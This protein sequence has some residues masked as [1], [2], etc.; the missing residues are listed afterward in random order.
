MTTTIATT[1]PAYLTLHRDIILHAD[2]WG[3]DLQILAA[4]FGFEGITGIATLQTGNL[5]AAIDAGAGMSLNWADLDPAAPMR[6]VTSATSVIGVVGSGFGA[7]VVN[8][9]AMP[10]EFSFP[11]L[12]STLDPTD[13]A[14]T[15]NTGEVVTPDAAAINP[16]YDLNERSTVVV[17]GSF[18]NRLTPGTEG[19]IYPV[20]IEIVA[21]DTPLMALGPDGLVSAVGLT[22]DSTNPYV[23]DGGPQLV[24][25]KLTV[26]SP[27]G[28]FAPVGIGTASPNDGQALYGD[29]AEYRLRLFTSGGFSP[30]GVSGFLPDEFARFF[31]LEAIDADGRTVVIDQAGVDYDLGDGTLRVVGLAELGNTA[32][33]G[34]PAY[35]QE[36]HDNQ[37]D[38]VLAG[39]EAAMRRLTVVEIPTAAEEGYSD[40]YNPGGPGQTPT[41][42]VT[43]TQPA[44]AQRFDI[45]IALDDA[46]AVSYAAQSVADYDLADNLSVVF[47]L[48]DPDDG[49]HVYTASTNEASSFLADGWKELG[50]PFSSEQGGSGPLQI[51]RLYDADATDYVLTAD[52]DEI[53]ALT[54][55][56]YVDEG[57]VFYGL[58]DPA[59]GA[60]PIYRFYSRASSD[61]LYTADR[62]AG[63]EAGY[64]LE[65]VAWYAVD[66][67]GSE[68]PNLRTFAG[69]GNDQLLG[70][71]GD[72]WFNGGGG[73]DSL[74]GGAGE[75][76]LAGGRGDDSVS[77]GPGEDTMRGGHGDDWLSGGDDADRMLGGA[78]DDTMLGGAGNDSLRGGHGA[79][80]L[81]GGSDADVI[82]GGAGDDVL[83]GG[84]GDDTLIGGRGDDTMSGG[85]GADRFSFAYRFG[86]DTI[87]DFDVDADE[88]HFSGH[89]HEDLTQTGTHRGLLIESADGASS[90]LLVGL[91]VS[92]AM[93]I[94]IV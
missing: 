62:S 68:T 90:V 58:A 77:G 80:R 69:R 91:D 81:A 65:G 44:A 13:I 76:R 53:D 64:R 84:S 11:V 38:I 75:D 67:S 47:A 93:D 28:D 43:Y 37:F 4:G 5:D 41:E 24:G 74:Y 32:E 27:V 49:T 7:A 35:Y 70:G 16:N 50:V 26:L 39:D 87:R 23:E 12:P 10:I 60:A 14:I 34:D 1:M 6:N 46:R 85:D 29:E 48:V 36:D 86:D 89:G 9:D 72:D 31:R 33:A 78:G 61:H 66:L 57:V 22:H 71:P 40:I 83:R 3:E 2:L 8:A 21:D 15:L 17:F 63:L 19:A 25:A 56:G 55:D 92:D 52:Q 54:D 88:L 30:D 73:D 59:E 45:E 94:A 20:G 42:G 82:H 79:D 51:H 18:G